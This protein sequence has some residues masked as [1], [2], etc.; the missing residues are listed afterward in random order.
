MTTVRIAVFFIFFSLSISIYPVKQ[1]KNVE[2]LHINR[3]V[4]MIKLYNVSRNSDFTYIGDTVSDSLKAFLTQLGTYDLIDSSIIDEAIEQN[5]ININQMIWEDTA[6][7][8][9]EILNADVV[10]F[11]FYTIADKEVSIFLNTVDVKVRKSA[12][13]LTKDAK[14]GVRIIDSCKEI[15]TEMGEKIKDALPPYEKIPEKRDLTYQNIA[16]GTVVSGS[17]L[18][19]TGTVGLILNILVFDPY[20]N[21]FSD[22]ATAPAVIDYAT[23]QGYTYLYSAILGTTI[24]FI[25]LGVILISISVPFFY[26]NHKKLTLEVNSNYLNF[27]SIGLKLNF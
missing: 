4:S 1:T 5:S 11:G 10:V 9:G 20:I 25:S 17:T 27:M 7:K 19:L 16:V 15:A 8:I 3:K 18:L 6:I 26:L 12:F 21:K 13:S 14:L 22:T 2:T 24:G 23:Y